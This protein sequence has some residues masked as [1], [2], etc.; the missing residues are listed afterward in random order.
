M[1]PKH[2]WEGFIR[3][4]EMIIDFY[5]HMNLSWMRKYHSKMA[6]MSILVKAKIMQVQTGV[7]ENRMEVF[8]EAYKCLAPS[9]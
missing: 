1:L 8:Q 6:K 5:T 7:G 3:V 2:G 4:M 9:S